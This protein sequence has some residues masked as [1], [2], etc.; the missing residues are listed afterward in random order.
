VNVATLSIDALLAT[1][2][3]ERDPARRWETIESCLALGPAE[4]VYALIQAH[5]DVISERARHWPPWRLRA[6]FA[7]QPA[8][9][10][11]GMMLPW[12]IDQAMAVVEASAEPDRVLDWLRDREAD[13]LR[14]LRPVLRGDMSPQAAREILNVG[15]EADAIAIE[16]AWQT[17]RAFMTVWPASGSARVQAKIQRQGLALLDKAREVLMNALNA[18]PPR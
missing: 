8:A 5:G 9:A 11:I 1:L 15:P 3:A 13:R 4:R 18:P 17:L 7:G 14:R 10:L 12:T 6:V 16:I 2:A